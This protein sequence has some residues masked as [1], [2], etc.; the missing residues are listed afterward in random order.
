VVAGVAKTLAAA[1]NRL[2]FYGKVK[3]A[4]L[5]ESVPRAAARAKFD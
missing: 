1:R 3:T 4:A 5:S 2:H